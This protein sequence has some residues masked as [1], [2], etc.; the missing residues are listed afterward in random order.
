MAELLIMAADTGSSDPV[1]KWYGAT[2][3]NVQEDGHEWGREEG[4]PIFFILKVPG[5]SKADADEYLAEWRHNP[6]Y[7]V[8]NSQPAQDSYRIRLESSAVSVSGKGAITLAQVQS[9]FTRWGCTI[10]SATSNSVTFNIRIFDALT[11]EGFWGLDVSGITFTETEYNQS[12][13]SHLIAVGPGPT[14]AQIQQVCQRESVVYVAPRSF[15]ATRAEA[16]QKLQDEIVERFRDIGIARRRWFISAAGM[17]ALQ[18]AGGI[19]S[20][21]PQQFV[22]NMTDGFTV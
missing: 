21:T 7:T 18:N 11:S 12:T 9:F 22:A 15:I 2:I 17:T 4:P 6:T 14:E 8:V 3:V 16:R 10:Q 20:V 1:G 13:G 5:V 19:L